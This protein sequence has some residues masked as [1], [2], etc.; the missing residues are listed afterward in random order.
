MALRPV[1]FTAIPH[2]KNF[3]NPVSTL[4]NPVA[5]NKMFAEQNLESSKHLAVST[6]SLPITKIAEQNLAL[7]PKSNSCLLEKLNF[8]YINCET[9]GLD[10]NNNQMIEKD[11]YHLSRR[12]ILNKFYPF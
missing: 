1:K 3:I 2:P 4:L 8:A 10:V 11:Y 6:I 12:K 5:T 9:T 7:L